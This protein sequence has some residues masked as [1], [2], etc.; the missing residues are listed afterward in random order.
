M[1]NQDDSPEPLSKRQKL[2]DGNEEAA[3]MYDEATARMILEATVIDDD[4][5]ASDSDDDD[6]DDELQGFDPDDAALDNVYYA[7][8]GR[9]E[10]TPMIYFA[11]IGDV[12]MCRYLISRGASTT[13]V[14]N[15][16]FY[17]PMYMA[18]AHDHIDVCKLLYEN[19][20]QNDICKKTGYN[21]TPF[22]IASICGYNQVVRWLVL[23]GALC[24]DNNSEDVEVGRIILHNEGVV[25]SCN[26]LVE[27]AAEVIQSHFALITFLGGALPPEPGEGQCRTLQC[28][29]GH[30]GVRKHI[31]DFVGIKITRRK[32]LRILQ[33]LVEVLPPYINQV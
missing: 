10:I 27:W 23:N 31:A 19:G 1:S 18:A 20:A 12:K 7:D 5:D 3:E 26:A 32:H 33:S 4:D 30:P 29:S 11:K 21:L 8:F 16:T 15:G 6:D 17:F 24:A 22:C 14:V 2:G 13:K 25:N 9:Y 28:L